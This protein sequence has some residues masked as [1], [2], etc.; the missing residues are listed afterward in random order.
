MF[1]QFIKLKIDRKEYSGSSVPSSTRNKHLDI[2][3]VPVSNK[4]GKLMA[5]GDKD[6]SQQILDAVHSLTSLMI[7]HKRDHH[8]A[9]VAYVQP[10]IIEFFGHLL[11]ITAGRENFDVV[12]EVPYTIE[13]T[14][15]YA[16]GTT[17]ETI[18]GKTDHCLKIK[19]SELRVLTVEDKALNHELGHREIS[20]AMCEI[21]YEVEQLYKTLRYA[22]DEFCGILHNGCMWVFIF[23][24]QTMRDVYWNYVRLEPA[25][26]GY[27]IN[28]RNCEIIAKF[29][30]HALYTAEVIRRVVSNGIVVGTGL[31]SIPEEEGE[32][33]DE[34]N[35]GDSEDVEDKREGK[36]P[37]SERKNSKTSGSSKKQQ[38]QSGKQSGKAA[39]SKTILNNRWMDMENFENYVLPLTTSNVAK[40]P[41]RYYKLLA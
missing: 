38:K 25:F 12:K 18:R 37:L 24:Q 16:E 13:F 11:D 5:F 28:V 6:M 21:I 8:I 2:S 7:Q 1:T 19:Q 17:V 15:N 26:E 3:Q 36:K 4:F 22:P 27:V 30:E 23:R 41:V 40:Q 31:S 14:T 9:E 35:G 32:S 10:A 34:G 33:G 20:Q 29:I 39:N